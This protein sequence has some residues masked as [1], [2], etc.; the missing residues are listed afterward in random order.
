MLHSQLIRSSTRTPGENRDLEART[1]LALHCDPLV[2]AA[3][4]G[5]P[6]RTCSRIFSEADVPPYPR[7]T[8]WEADSDPMDR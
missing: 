8:R 6:A 5:V 4:I 1:R 2:L 7:R 3:V